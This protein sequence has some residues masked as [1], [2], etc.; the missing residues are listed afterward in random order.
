M[1]G[2]GY[3]EVSAKLRLEPQGWLSVL[4]GSAAGQNARWPFAADMM[5]EPLVSGP[6]SVRV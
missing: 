2:E 4:L 3:T 1:K 6:L 5:G